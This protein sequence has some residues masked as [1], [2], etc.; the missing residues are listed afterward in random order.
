MK[1]QEIL[2]EEKLINQAVDVLID[3]LGF[4][5][6]VRFLACTSESKRDSVKKHQE[7]QAKLNKNVF[8]NELFKSNVQKS[9][10][11]QIVSLNNQR[12]PVKPLFIRKRE[13]R[14]V[15]NH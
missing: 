10:I 5:Q 13:L 2:E 6:T 15:V 7:W 3:N 11:L 14:L 9:P 8:F 1:S 12:H 4:P